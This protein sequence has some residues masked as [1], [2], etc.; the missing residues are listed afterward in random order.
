[1]GVTRA[2]VANGAS[3]L[4]ELRRNEVARIGSY[5]VSRSSFYSSLSLHA[6]S[7]TA[8]WMEASVSTSTPQEMTSPRKAITAKSSHSPMLILATPMILNR[9]AID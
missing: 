3:N 9:M 1:M 6:T 5:G 7:A 2:S 8:P 4:L